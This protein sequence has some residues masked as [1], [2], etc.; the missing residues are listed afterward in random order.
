MPQVLE[1]VAQADQADT[2]QS[3]GQVWVLHCRTSDKCLHTAPLCAAA[4]TVL[5][6]REWVPEPQEW[7]HA[8]QALNAVTTQSMGQNTSLQVRLDSRAGQATPPCWAAVATVRARDWV[9]LPQVLVQADQ[10]EKEDTTQS[11]G[12]AWLLQVRCWSSGQS[13]PPCWATRR[14]FTG[15]VW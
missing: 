4:V 9:P 11:T 8:D 10:A 15:R 3:M 6:E 12:Q 1:H 7:V 5:L 13:T 14:I 2:T